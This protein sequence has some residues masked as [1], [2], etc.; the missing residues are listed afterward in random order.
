VSVDA[1]VLVEHRGPVA[2]VVLHRPARRNALTLEAIGTLTETFEKLGGSDVR[3]IVLHGGEFFCSGLDTKELLTSAPPIEAWIATH[4]ALA[5]V[6]APIVA[7]L[8]GGAINAGAALVLAADLLVAGMTSYLQIG[9]AAMG[10]TPT[11]NAAWLAVRHPAAVAS[12]LALGC[13]RVSGPDLHRLGIA[14]EVVPDDRVVDR[15]RALAAE[16][17]AYAGAG[18]ARTKRVLRAARSEGARFDAA[19]EAALAAS[20]GG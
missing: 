16:L 10:M 17:A 8:A 9:E 4:R 3:A 12:Q 18:A 5:R 7:C 2:E 20:R 13:R 15:G 6:E 14:A 19:V 11:V 1:C